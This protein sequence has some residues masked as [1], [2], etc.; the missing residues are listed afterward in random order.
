MEDTDGEGKLE[1]EKEIEF[2][3]KRGKVG[4]VMDYSKFFKPLDNNGI[5]KF[6]RRLKKNGMKNSKKDKTR[7]N[8]FK[9]KRQ[10]MGKKGP[11]KSKKSPFVGLHQIMKQQKLAIMHKILGPISAKKIAPVIH[12][13]IAVNKQ[14]NDSNENFNRYRGGNLSNTSLVN[15]E[16]AKE[17]K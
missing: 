13:N 12:G 15:N 10:N 2:L 11:K 5:N 9:I 14:E 4:A 3:A 6:D 16:E 17:K 8:R 1:I 7:I